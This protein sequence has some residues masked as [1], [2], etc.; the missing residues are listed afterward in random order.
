L[1]RLIFVCALWSLRSFFEAMEILGVFVLSPSSLNQFGHHSSARTFFFLALSWDS[2]LYLALALTTTILR[3]IDSQW[4]NRL[5]I[6]GRI[7]V[8]HCR[9]SERLSPLSGFGPS[10]EFS[11]KM[12]T[13]LFLGAAFF[14]PLVWFSFFCLPLFLYPPSSNV[15]GFTY[16]AFEI[17]QWGSVVETFF[18]G[19]FN[20]GG[21]EFILF[22][23]FFLS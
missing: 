18:L 10:G 9:V 19:A 15:L 20:G 12:R 21:Y 8:C 23:G 14:S 22:A 2:P 1:V 7:F 6:F 17:F 3:R 4:R 5:S 16:A 11:R 13:Y